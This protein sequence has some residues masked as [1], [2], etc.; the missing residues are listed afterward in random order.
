VEIRSPRATRPWQ[1][2]LEPLSGYLLL[3]TA[4]AHDN[5]LHGEPF[6]FGPRAEQNRTV[7]ELLTDLAAHWGTDR[8]PEAYRITAN[9]PFYEAS[10]LKLNCDKALFHL[11][12]EPTLVYPETIRLVGEWYCAYFSGQCDMLDLTIRQIDTFERVACERHRVWAAC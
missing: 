2:V 9:V 8:V 12:W 5:R 6:N 10:L 3:G 1:H 4:L 7:T 11:R